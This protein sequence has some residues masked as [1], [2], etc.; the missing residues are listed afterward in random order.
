MDPFLG[1]IRAVGFNYAPR[2]WALCDGSL[3]A[4]R[5]NNALFAILGTTYGGDGKQ[6]FALPDLRSRT[7]VNAG[8]GPG[9]SSY[10]LG[11]ATG[12]ETVTLDINSMPAH[13]HGLNP[14]QVH[15]GTGT[16]NSPAGTLLADSVN[17]QY[18][19]AS[20]KG[21]TMAA[22][23][24]KGSASAVGGNLPHPNIMPYLVVNYIIA[25]AGIF[26]PRS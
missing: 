18:G 14:L 11:N 25:T 13:I 17:F 16:N 7:I 10:P 24:I 12:T 15:D 21:V 2:G 26:P 19:E 4:I 6:N 22:G 1:E 3:L 23:M 8:Q 9:L 20:T 5:S